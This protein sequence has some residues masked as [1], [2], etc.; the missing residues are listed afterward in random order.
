MTT[1]LQRRID[2][3]CDHYVLEVPGSTL[4]LALKQAADVVL[5]DDQPAGEDGFPITQQFLTGLIDHLEA[6]YWGFS[7]VVGNE[8]QPQKPDDPNAILNS[9][10]E[11]KQF[12]L[13]A[14]TV[15]AGQYYEEQMQ[16]W[17]E[18]QAVYGVIVALNKALADH[19]AF[20]TALIQEE[21]PQGR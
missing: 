14:S 15:T 12:R 3:A 6:Q 1:E 10:S 16:D 2:E 8:P 5:T 4:K 17:R 19:K 21:F 20:I 9:L 18:R 13:P 7:P 11:D